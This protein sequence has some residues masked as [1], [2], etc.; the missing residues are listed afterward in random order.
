MNFTLYQNTS[1]PNRVG[2]SISPVASL[3]GVIK[4][5]T[6][7]TDPVIEVQLDVYPSANY[8]YIP[9]FNRYYFIT[10][11]EIET[12]QLYLIH[13]KCDVLQTYASQ[14]RACE[15]TLSRQEQLYNL[16]LPDDKLPTYQDTFTITNLL[17]GSSSFA[18]AGYVLLAR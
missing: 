10:D 9:E 6:S 11:I 12:N 3:N 1:E 4:D 18:N 16:Y 5:T 2:K 13:C 7:V 8:A 17:N 14:I 15:A